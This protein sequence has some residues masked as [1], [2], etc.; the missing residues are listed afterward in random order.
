VLH[1]DRSAKTLFVVGNDGK[2]P[3]IDAL[4][5]S[6]TL[7]NE[8]EIYKIRESEIIPVLER[9]VSNYSRSKDSLDASRENVPRRSD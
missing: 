9:L 8:S 4:I 2:Q 5:T 3:S 1:P 7:P 6:G